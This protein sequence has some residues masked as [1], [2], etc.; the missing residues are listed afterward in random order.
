MLSGSKGKTR[1]STKRTDSN[2]PDYSLW[3]W[4][5]LSVAGAVIAVT[6]YSVIVKQRRRVSSVKENIPIVVAYSATMADT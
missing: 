3:V 2:S 6:I 4:A 1:S 5:G